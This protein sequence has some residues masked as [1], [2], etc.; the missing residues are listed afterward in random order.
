MPTPRPVKSRRARDIAAIHAAIKELGMEDAAY[1]DMLFTVARVRSCKD[2]DFTGLQRVRDHLGKCGAT[3]GRA[4][5]KPESEWAFVFRAPAD[6]QPHLKKLYRQAQALKVG[7]AYIEGI[8]KRMAGAT[9]PLEFCDADRL[10]Q[11]VQAIEV[12]KR[13]QGV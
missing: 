8:A 11:I 10:H 7:K 9:Q 3:F 12:Y 6:R 1:R 5:G 13:R 2:L 4:K